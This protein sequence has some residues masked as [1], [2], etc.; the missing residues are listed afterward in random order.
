L[1]T[2]NE[3]DFEQH[4]SGLLDRGDGFQFLGFAS[5]ASGL[6][7]EVDPH[8]RLLEPLSWTFEVTS[9]SGMQTPVVFVTLGENSCAQVLE[10]YQGAGSTEEAWMQAIV[11]YVQKPS[12]ELSVLKVLDLEKQP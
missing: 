4:F 9:G 5:M 3:A 8:A 2:G 11:S 10:C 1:L 7:I 12:S 6:A